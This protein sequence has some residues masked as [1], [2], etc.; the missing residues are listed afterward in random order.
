MAGGDRDRQ[1]LSRLSVSAEVHDTRG[2]VAVEIELQDVANVCAGTVE[3][4]HLADHGQ[5]YGKGGVGCGE[6]DMEEL[7][8]VDYR[9]NNFESVIRCGGVNGIALNEHW[10]ESPLGL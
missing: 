2:H 7:G 5:D 1:P 3:G 6:G 9:V 4:G 10:L 8:A